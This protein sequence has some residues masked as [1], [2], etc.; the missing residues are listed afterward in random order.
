[1]HLTYLTDTLSLG[2][3]NQGV[4]AYLTSTQLTPTLMAPIPW[5]LCSKWPA[6][7]VGGLVERRN[8]DALSQIFEKPDCSSWWN[9]ATLTTS[10]SISAFSSSMQTGSGRSR[11]DSG[12][13]HKLSSTCGELGLMA[14][15]DLSSYSL[16]APWVGSSKLLY[17]APLQLVL[18]L[19]FHDNGR[20]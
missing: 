17:C 3:T 2:M 7:N 14:V 4:F 16:Y 13:C 20:N 11:W 5:N 19:L 10:F 15:L 18:A 9:P 6:Y 8:Q 1:M 12:K